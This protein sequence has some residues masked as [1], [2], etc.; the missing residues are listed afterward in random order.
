MSKIQKRMQELKIPLPELTKPVGAYVPAVRVGN[1]VYSSGQLPLS[2]NR[3]IFPGRVGKEVT[4]EN[5]Q[6]AA[7]AAVIN[8]LAAIHWCIRDLDKI[9]KIVR[10][11]AHV[12]ASIGY[13]ELAK[14]INPASDLLSEIFG[15]EIG[16]HSR[17]T[18]GCLE[19]PLGACVE[20]DLIAAV[21]GK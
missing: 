16:S 18:V 13:L 14:I 21:K 10:L 11:N 3:L 17:V 12:C 6:R 7:K 4:P 20:I 2:D 5:A 1:L 9:E 8:A 19:L 15:D